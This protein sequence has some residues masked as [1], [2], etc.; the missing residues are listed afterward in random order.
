VKTVPL[1]GKKAAGRVTIVD[2]GDYTL[3]MRYRW[4]VRETVRP[5]GGID[6]PYAIAN[7]RHPDG[8]H[9]TVFLH[10]V[11]L[12]ITGVDHVSGDGLDNRRENLRLATKAENQHNRRSQHGSSSRYKGVDW[13]KS[14]SK[15]RA[16]INLN[17]WSRYLGCF[18][19]EAE[20]ARAYD[21][22]AREAWGKYARLNFPG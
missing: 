19:H 5:G 1:H 15:W 8:R 16:R 18:D 3:A 14:F 13:H 4:C 22:A 12:G 17:G 11:I 20:A 10:Q 7:V 21:K 2:D 6:G 9:G